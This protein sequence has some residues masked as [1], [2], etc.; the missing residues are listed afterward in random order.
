MSLP[1]VYVICGLRVLSTSASAAFFCFMDCIISL[2]TRVVLA[3]ALAD[4]VGEVG[5]WIAI[6]IGWFLADFVGYGYWFRMYY[7]KQVN[8]VLNCRDR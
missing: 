3:Y 7:K 6:P 2:G 1:A 5:I 4:P 8:R